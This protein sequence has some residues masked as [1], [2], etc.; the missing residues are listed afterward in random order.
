VHKG[1]LWYI[2]FFLPYQ[3]P[4]FL[5]YQKLNSTSCFSCDR[6]EDNFSKIVQHLNRQV[7]ALDKLTKLTDSIKERASEPAD[8]RLRCVTSSKCFSLSPAGVLRAS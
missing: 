3:K 8:R 2:K 1:K 6:K 4:I 7:E 5:P